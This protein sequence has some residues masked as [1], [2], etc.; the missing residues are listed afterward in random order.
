ME[1]SEEDYVNCKKPKGAPPRAILGE[2]GST[3]ID[4]ASKE[5]NKT[6]HGTP[7]QQVH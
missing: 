4:K 3:R 1:V 2:K 7:G 6:A 5:R